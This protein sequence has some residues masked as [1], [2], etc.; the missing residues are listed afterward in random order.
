MGSAAAVH[1]GDLRRIRLE[2][3]AARHARQ[4]LAHVVGRA[5]EVALQREFDVDLRALVAARGVEALDAFDAR[6]LVLDDL[7]DARL[8]HVRGGA[9]VTRLDV[10]H[11]ALDVGEFAQAEARD[12]AEPE[13]EQQQRHHRREDGTPHRQVGDLHCRTLAGPAVFASCEPDSAYRRHFRRHFRGAHRCTVTHFLRAFDDDP[14]TGREAREHLDTAGTAAA[15]AHFT[16]LGLAV[17]HHE[18]VLP[19]GFGRERLFGNHQRRTLVIGQRHVQEHAGS[20]CA[21]FV[22]QQ[23]AHRHRARVH[24]DARVDARDLAGEGA[25]RECRR[26]GAHRQTLAQAGEEIL[27]HREVELDDAGVVERG[28]HVAGAD[29]R[30]DAHAPQTH[31]PGEWRADHG[32]LRSG[33]WRRCSR[34]RF[35]LSVAS[36]WSNCAFD[37]ASVDMSSRLRL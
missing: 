18:H 12:G 35:A 22:G 5:V 14:L 23:G 9:A 29:E 6:D 3:Q 30:A 10:H 26:A 4:A 2:R 15:D 37:R 28:D 8:D 24:V 31:A 19:L 21:V 16:P 20:Q 7:R 32:V 17:V 11:R 1:L 13:D 27:R 36:S 33:R 25:A 34:A